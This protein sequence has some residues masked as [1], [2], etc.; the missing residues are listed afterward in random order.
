M[1][2]MPS[3]AARELSRR[4]VLEILGLSA[5]GAATLAACGGEREDGTGS[6]GGGGGPAEFAGA[7]PYQVPP[8]GHFNLMSGVTDSILGGGAYQDLLILP[9][10]MYYWDAKEWELLLAESYE[11]DEEAQTFSYTLRSGLTWSDGKP[12]TVEDVLTTF[13]CLR[14]MRNVVWNY[15][16]GIEADG[17]TVVFQMNNPSTVVERYV[18]RQGIFSSATY[19]EFAQRAQD[20][21]NSGKDLDSEE[22]EKLNQDLQKLRPKELIV[23]GPFTFDYRSITNAQLTLVKNDKG[24]LAD[25]VKFDTV[26]LFNGETPTI[27]PLVLNKRVDYATHGFPVATEREFENKGIRVL[28]P[29]VYS[30]PA[31]F[32]N[33]DKLPE[34]KDPNA[35]R[36]LA[37]A[38]NRDQNGAAALGDSGKG[39]KFMAGFSDIQVPEW[40]SQEE[41]DR[42][43]PYEFDRDKAASLLTQAGW[44]KQ[45]SRRRVSRRATS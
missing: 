1:N 15:L 27:T 13:W 43:N 37:H 39:V 26:T 29:P 16:S 30:G 32:I 41:Q 6:G 33:L 45:G 28:R 20:L 2:D 31:L 22:G 34:F 12:I 21:F 38:I 23:S 19:G 40:L 11:T 18:L 5:A 4:R 7:W 25:Q 14:I 35:R 3:L 24:Y 36:A 8:K 42:L 9:G 44:K 17:N 10:G